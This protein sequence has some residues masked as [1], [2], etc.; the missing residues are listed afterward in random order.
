[1]EDDEAGEEF[2]ARA[3]STE[4][5]PTAREIEEHNLDHRVFRAWCPRCAKGRAEVYPRRSV[6][7]KEEREAPVIGIDYVC[8]HSEQD[9]E[10]EEEEKGM[11]MIVI[12][13]DRSKMVFARVVP[14]KGVEPCAVGSTVRTLEQLGYKKVIFKSDTEPA[15]LALKEAVRKEIDVELIKE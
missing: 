8:M 5:A 13:D 6:K 10:E 11:P 12:K 15:L 4:A 2:S 14:Q 3:R 7:N 9:K 1:M